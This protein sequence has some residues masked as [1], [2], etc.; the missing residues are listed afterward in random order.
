MRYKLLILLMIITSC[1]YFHKVAS[2]PAAPLS[3]LDKLKTKYTEV[4]AQLGDEWPSRTDCDALLWAGLSRSA[5]SHVDLTEAEYAPG[6]MHRRPTPE[7]YPNESASSISGDMLIGYMLGLWHSHDLQALQRLADYG[8]AHNW[9][10]G[11]GPI[12]RTVLRFNDQSLLGRAIWE[13]SEHQDDRSY[14]HF[15][16]IYFPVVEDYE[17]H[18]QVLSILLY[19]EIMGTIDQ[20]SYTRLSALC[21]ENP[22]DALM[23][24]DCGIYTG[25]MSI[26]TGLLLDPTYS[27]P[28]YVR[29]APNYS[30]VHWLL[31]ARVTLDRLEPI[32]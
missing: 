22:K 25:N 6:D 27:A 1:G 13:L 17:E 30:L 26:A 32:K 7:C 16:I 29:G 9:V 11:E 23:Q 5:G 14:R 2:K 3:N 8:E 10:M 24:A 4:L 20:D 12:S 31:A 15:P 18:L 28:S 21:T 19:G